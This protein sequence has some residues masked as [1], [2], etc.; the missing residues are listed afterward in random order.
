MLRCLPPLQKMGR[1]RVAEVWQVAGLVI[2]CSTARGARLLDQGWVRALVSALLSGGGVAPPADAAGNT[3]CPA[4]GQSP[5][6]SVST[7]LKMF[8]L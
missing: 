1:E 4:L 7:A 6:G 5:G 2:H 3:H 8:S